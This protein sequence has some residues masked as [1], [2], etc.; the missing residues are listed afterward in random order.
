MRLSIA[1]K[2][3]IAFAVPILLMVVSSYFV[4]VQVSDLVN[5]A[6]PTT[7][8][9][10]NLTIGVNRSLAEL[11]SYTILGGDEQAAT[12]FKQNRAMAWAT[13]DESLTK[14]KQLADRDQST[15]GDLRSQLPEI[16]R[17]V[18]KLRQAQEKIESIAQTDANIPAL[19]LLLKKA[20]P[21]ADEMLKLLTAM[22]TEEGSLEAIP[23]RKQ[24]LNALADSRGSLATSVASIRAYLLSGQQRFRD[25]FTT[26]SKANQEAGNSVQL[27]SKLFTSTQAEQWTQYVE[28]QSQLMT[29]ANTVLELREGDDWN[30]ANYLMESE[31]VPTA[32]SLTASLFALQSNA[33]E[34]QDDATKTV[35][36]SFV[37]STGI[38][39][40]LAAVVAFYLSRAIGRTVGQLAD[41]AEDIASG[42]LEG[43][44]LDTLSGDE[45]GQ[46]AESFNRMAENLRSM[47]GT[48]STQDEMLAILNSTADAI[49]SF[50]E[51]G[52][53]MSFNSAAERLFG[54]QRNDAIGKNVSDLSPQRN[55]GEEILSA[56][57][58][59]GQD[60][61]G[62]GIR[63]DG[64]EFAMS[65]R[66]TEL[67]QD[68]KR[69]FLATIQDVTKSKAAHEQQERMLGA[70]RNAVDELGTSSSEIMATTSMQASTAQ[71]Q[72]TSVT[73]TVATVE[74]LTHSASE[75]SQRAKAVA[76][77]AQRANEV[78]RDGRSAVAETKG[79]MLEVRQQT[80][81][82][83]EN[84]LALSE[85]AQTIGEIIATVNEIADQTNLL[86]LN[87]AIEASRAGEHGKGFAVV[88]GEVKALA[89]QSKKATEQIRQILG[90][91]QQATNTAVLSTEQSTKSVSR[92][93]EI[94]QQA[95]ETIEK[96]TQTISEASRSAAQI[97][98]S[99]GQQEQGMS[100]IND[101]MRHIDG[102]TQQSLASA[103]QSE[104]SAGNL[105][106]LGNRLK[107]LMTSID[108]TNT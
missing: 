27:R 73:Q 54:Y 81:S 47:I 88:A 56:N 41:R 86:A 94:V 103:R 12:S 45:L 30:Q 105:N 13:I 72:A 95:D 96:L 5:D 68:G 89:E 34:A 63:R 77:S 65:L 49:I 101:S 42:N 82:T 92:A 48:M 33:I 52:K 64:S 74:E 14:L 17:N 98:A 84:I 50:G 90:E 43:D 93:A 31:A 46:L 87:A 75:T 51:A 26:Q 16:N 21:T 2:M 61:E 62:I 57:A 66:L 11:T 20:V 76:D 59:I 99:V 25:A 108:S 1:Q 39:C 32:K 100:Q 55:G 104:A 102:A 71:Q 10:D 24:L 91:I 79:A 106:D 7:T 67:E 15:T 38:A 28:L 83:S 40:L 22:I 6:V 58:Q 80:E 3:T 29:V 69:R 60:R 70:I 36:V 78:S 44:P 9:C 35:L 19:D 107:E 97:V 37:A 8:A 4:Y 23:E 18:E 85:R 53:I